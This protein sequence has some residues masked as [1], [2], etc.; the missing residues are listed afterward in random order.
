ML[1][2]HKLSTSK[3]LI[4]NQTFVEEITRLNRN[5]ESGYPLDADCR[6]VWNIQRNIGLLTPSSIHF[7]KM[8]YE[9][10]L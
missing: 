4:L 8:I 6:E 7:M 10:C 9:L 3:A 2:A 5:Q 1:K